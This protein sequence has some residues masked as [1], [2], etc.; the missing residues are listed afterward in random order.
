MNLTTIAA[1][2]LIALASRK[3]HPIDGRSIS[4]FFP[5]YDASP[6]QIS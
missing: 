5:L 4:D 6:I 1:G 3:P 2:R